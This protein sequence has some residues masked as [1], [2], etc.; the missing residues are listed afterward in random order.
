LK[1]LIFAIIGLAILLPVN[2][3]E[4]NVSISLGEK[5]IRTEFEYDIGFDD[6]ATVTSVA[7]GIF[8]NISYYQTPS[9]SYALEF[10]AFTNASSSGIYNSS[11]TTTTGYE[12][13]VKPNPYL[14]WQA[15]YTFLPS[16]TVRPIVLGGVSYLKADVTAESVIE[17]NTTRTVTG[18]AA[19]SDSSFGLIYGIGLDINFYKTVSFVLDYRIRPDIADNSVDEINGSLKYQF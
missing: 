4:N 5:S 15:Q 7:T 3:D 2:A 16:K 11:P 8:A 9:V 1:Q 17:T 13:T 19:K 6:N 14:S 10:V 18:S 12:V